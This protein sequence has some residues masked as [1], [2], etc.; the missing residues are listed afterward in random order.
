MKRRPRRKINKNFIPNIF[1]VFNMFLG[2]MAIGMLFQGRPILAGWLILYAGLFDAVD[3]KLARMLGIPSKFGT[4]FDSLA[5]TISFCVAP[6]FLLYTTYISG[7]SPLI[8]GFISFIPLLF[9]TIRLAIFNLDTDEDPK[10]YFTGMPTPVAAMTIFGY[11]LFNQRLYQTDGDPRIALVIA[12]AL[13]FLMVS[14]IRFNK[15]P[16]LSFKKGKSNTTAL[17]SVII[18]LISLIIWKGLVL[19]PVAVFYITWNIINWMVSPHRT[20]HGL[21]IKA[22]GQ[23]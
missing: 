7:L 9:G 20:G 8:G 17:L 5:D 15:F 4:E 1:T 2:F 12:I 19:F 18:M 21:T 6:S 16:M 10:S 11:F 3:G 13:G 22:N 14:K 23:E